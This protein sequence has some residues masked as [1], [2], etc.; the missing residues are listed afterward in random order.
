MAVFRRSCGHRAKSE[1]RSIFMYFTCLRAPLGGLGASRGGLVATPR[2]LE[3]PFTVKS[4]VKL[5]TI[6]EDR[7]GS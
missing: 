4:D 7:R 3:A 1:K 2:G 5:S 6:I